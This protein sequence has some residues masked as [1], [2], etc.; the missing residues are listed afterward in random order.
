[1][2]TINILAVKAELELILSTKVFKQSYVLSSFL[3]YVVIETLQE[4]PNEIKEYSIAVKALGKPS[5]FNPQ[6]DAVI[7]IH[8]GRLRRILHEYYSGEGSNNPMVILMQKGSY[9]PEFVL[10]NNVN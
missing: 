1:M 3:R 8:A 7:R 5:D 2:S 10:R 6:L 9:I 4:K